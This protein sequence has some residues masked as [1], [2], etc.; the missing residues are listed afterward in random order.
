MQKKLKI[1]LLIMLLMIG[2]FVIKSISPRLFTSIRKSG[3]IV[4]RI[5][6]PDYQSRLVSDSIVN[7]RG[8]YTPQ[9]KENI[10]QQLSVALKKN[11][12]VIAKLGADWCPPCREMKPILQELKIELNGKAI[13]LDLDIDQNKDLAKKHKINAI[14]TTLFYNSKGEF[15]K[16]II[17]FI[18]KKQILR[19][20]DN[21]QSKDPLLNN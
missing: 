8:S 9:V 19:E 5:S 20:L 12:P 10:A 3:L 17:G 4:E 1:I 18:D 13:V 21:L 11:L 7:N 15:K 16:K 2:F 6:S 14:P